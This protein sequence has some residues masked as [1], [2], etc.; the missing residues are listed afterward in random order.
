MVQALRLRVHEARTP[1]NLISRMP[2]NLGITRAPF[3]VLGNL[4]KEPR[5]TKREKVPTG[6]PRINN[7]EWELN[8]PPVPSRLGRGKLRQRHRLCNVKVPNPPPKGKHP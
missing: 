3:L 1:T 7:Y 2:R 4:Y 5:T 6:R 8:R